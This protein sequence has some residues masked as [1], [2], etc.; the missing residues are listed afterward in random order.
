[1]DQAYRRSFDMLEITRDMFLKSRES[2]RFREDNEIDIDV[3]DKDLQVNKYER[4]VRR[5]VFNHLVVSGPET[6][7]SGLGLVS[8]IIDIERLGDYAKNMVALAQDHPGKL[9]G[10]QLED[11]ICRIEAAVENNFNQTKQCFV[12]GDSKMALKLLEEY[13]WVNKACD[14][15]LKVLVRALDPTLG[16]GDGA[17]LALYSRQ[18]KRIN[19]HLRN[20][21]TSVVN[22]FDRI[23]F[24]PPKNNSEGD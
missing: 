10:G 13:S 23:G 3:R 9:H 20:I 16:C 24:D 12:E 1:M 4:E 11:D 2:L 18:L 8:I 15:C 17:A 5:M 14:D 7:A 22:P 6:L 21:T 19:S